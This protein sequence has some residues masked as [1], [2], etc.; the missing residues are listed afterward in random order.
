MWIGSTGQACRDVVRL[1]TI[2]LSAAR[3]AIRLGDFWYT[4]LMSRTAE[5]RVLMASLV[6]FAGLLMIAASLPPLGFIVGRL[7][8]TVGIGAGFSMLSPFVDF[9]PDQDPYGWLGWLGWVVLLALGIYLLLGGGW[10]R[11]RITAPFGSACSECG[12]DLR[13]VRHDSCPECDT[14]LPPKPVAPS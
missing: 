6:R 3:N 9:G 7:I 1:L 4:A 13:G 14:P 12:Y 5:H 8:K 11:R 10:I 2:G